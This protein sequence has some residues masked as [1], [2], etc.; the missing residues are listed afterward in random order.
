[1]HCT[2]MATQYC[3]VVPPCIKLSDCPSDPCVVTKRC[4]V[5][6]YSWLPLVCLSAVGVSV[7]C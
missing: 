2:E 3:Q 6:I 4:I 5:V 1:M 7:L